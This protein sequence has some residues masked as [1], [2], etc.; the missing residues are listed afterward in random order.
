LAIAKRS[1]FCGA[2]LMS[3]LLSKEQ[4]D[5]TVRA[6][7][8]DT[9]GPPLRPEEVDD[10]A[11]AKHA[12]RLGF[13]NRWQAE[14]L[15][16]GRNKF[17]LG[18]Y[19][20]VDEIGKGGMG[21]VFK[22]EHSM[23]GRVEAIKVLPRE[24]T[25]PEA[26]ASFQRE[27]RA[28]AQ[29]DHPNLARLSYAGQ[30]GTRYFFVTEYVPGTDLRKLV[31]REGRLNMQEAATIVS[32]AAQGL[33]HAHRCGLVHRDVKPG[34]LLVTPDGRTKVIDLGLAGFTAADSPTDPRAGKIVGTAD[35][36]APETIASPT[37]VSPTSDIYSLGC[38]LYYAVTGKVP[39]PG[40]TTAEKMR[41]HCD[42][43]EFPHD[44][45]KFNPD[46]DE[47]FLEI[48]ADMMEKDPARRISSAAEIV[49]RLAPW[50]L[51]TV[52]NSVRVDEAVPPV[53][54]TEPPPIPTARTNSLS[55]QAHFLDEEVPSS[56]KD[57][58][59]AA[60]D[61][62]ESGSSSAQEFSPLEGDDVIKLG[63]G[64]Y[65]YPSYMLAPLLLLLSAAIIG[66]VLLAI[67]L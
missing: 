33:D 6:A 40:G 9:V 18:E 52:P 11:I 65:V 43:H 31:R 37:N 62:T 10:E 35:Y 51:D 32:Q 29:L 60:L 56:A 22:A 25:S 54:R 64:L 8:A 45:R 14:H 42:P 19:L 20:I 34:N 17:T 2:A 53:P 21:H 59:I 67:W 41:R 13:I 57:S 15:K 55:I 30:D 36:L 24:K 66:I 4:L 7:C 26:I 23:L 1:L 38:T 58:I 44:P 46:L 47:A 16:K 48:L 12:V 49:R 63:M 3:G 5:A 61:S 28:H 27:I 39:Y 50:T